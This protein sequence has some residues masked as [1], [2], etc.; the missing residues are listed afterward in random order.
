MERI[1][2]FKPEIARV[3]LHRPVSLACAKHVHVDHSSDESDNETNDINDNL[4]LAK[5]P[6]LESKLGVSHTL[7][8]DGY[9]H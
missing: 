2:Q 4:S 8:Y 1:S 9:E 3:L 7:R 6:I 5:K